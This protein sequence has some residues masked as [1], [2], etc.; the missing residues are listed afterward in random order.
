MTTLPAEPI[1]VSYSRRDDE[2][3]RRIAFFL[4]DQGFKVWVDN[5]KLIPGTA[6]WEEAIE[7]ALKKAFAVVVVLS[8]DSKGS[9][10]VRR[11]I[12]YADQFNKRVFPVLV[13]GTEE[14]SLPLRLVT[15]QYVDLRKDEEAG[16]NAL[17]AAIHF[18]IGEKQTLEM[19]RPSGHRESASTLHP[20]PRSESFP[21]SPSQTKKPSNR[22]LPLGIFFAVFILCASTSWIGYR[23]LSPL[24]APDQPQISG[25]ESTVSLQIPVTGSFTPTS[26]AEVSEA[27]APDILSEYLSNVEIT[28]TDTF[29]DPSGSGWEID[30]GEIKDGTLEIS[31]DTNY[32]GAGSIKQFGAGEGAV[33][34]FT[35]PENVGFEIYLKN[36][37]YNSSKYKRF[38]FFISTD[39]IYVNAMNGKD[40]F[41]S[42][43]SGNLDIQPGI[44]YSAL[45]AILPN[46]EFLEVVWN[47]DD[48]SQSLVYRETMDSSWLD[49]DMSLY[50]GIGE[51]TVQ[52]DNYREIKFSGS[53]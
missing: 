33:I 3:M 20:A 43:F 6:A 30:N 26:T 47:A 44:N 22:I 40:K 51:G 7:T 21:A 18:Y 11:E 29:D 23:A 25:S 38:G 53:K 37:D 12:T 13:K 42:E 24:L 1:F 5:E 19:K 9:E 28:H 39:V 35:Y 36:G 27:P 8:P 31:A 41:G 16:L 48:P 15:R 2:V 32:Y 45:I 17:V 34:D 46:A 49:V 10:W 50:I 52:V 14:L 4:R